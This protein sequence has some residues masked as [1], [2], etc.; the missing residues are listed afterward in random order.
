MPPESPEPNDSEDSEDD[1]SAGS[2]IRRSPMTESNLSASPEVEQKDPRARTPNLR[3]PA[4]LQHWIVSR[5]PLRHCRMDVLDGLNKL[6]ASTS[7]SGR[8][9]YT[10]E[11]LFGDLLFHNRDFRNRWLGKNRERPYIRGDVQAAQ[12]ARCVWLHCEARQLYT[13]RDPGT[14]KYCL[15]ELNRLIQDYTSSSAASQL[16]PNSG[17]AFLRVAERRREKD[18][19]ALKKKIEACLYEW[20][21]AQFN[22][23]TP[24]MD[25]QEK[26][27][28]PGSQR[29]VSVSSRETVRKR[30][31]PEAQ[32]VAALIE[33]A[34]PAPV[35]GSGS[36]G[37]KREVEVAPAAA[38]L[39][40]PNVEYDAAPLADG[41]SAV[42][43]WRDYV[44]EEGVVRVVPLAGRPGWRP[45]Y[46]PLSSEYRRMTTT[47]EGA[48]LVF[49]H[50]QCGWVRMRS[51]L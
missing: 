3:A 28:R 44:D 20:D 2:L 40:Q 5:A 46:A 45:L 49:T 36:P 10:L 9:A 14:Y 21:D 37:T 18:I 41:A 19:V 25:F 24:S 39:P 17:N 48:E 47:E 51:R 34:A 12:L 42:M 27:K 35:M 15:G 32:A 16:S 31:R 22:E 43:L 6:S 7:T 23:K 13:E 38:L 4:E 26:Y 30:K 1:A 50:I 29:T 8:D 33:T 11:K